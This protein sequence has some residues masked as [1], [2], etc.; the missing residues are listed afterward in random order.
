[1]TIEDL[2]KRGDLILVTDSQDVQELKNYLCLEPQVPRID[3]CDGFFVKV[4]DGDYTEVYGFWGII[5]YLNKRIE[6]F[7]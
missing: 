3:Q 4:E 2:E 5:P 1:M 7:I 6:Q